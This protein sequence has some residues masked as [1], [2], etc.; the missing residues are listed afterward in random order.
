[1]NSDDYRATHIGRLLLELSHDF[2]AEANERIARKGFAFVRAAHIAVVAQVDEE[3]TE[4]GR[5]VERVGTTKQAVNKIIRQ[6]EELDVIRLE[7]SDRDSRVRVVRFTPAG[8]KFLKAAVDAVRQTEELYESEL[9]AT[10]FAS[11]K[12][13][14]LRLAEKRD[15]FSRT[16]DES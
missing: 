6:L 3:G 8:R 9:G 12:K 16:Y 4:L 14:L 13:N 7:T 15:V 10:A 1:M 2:V 5:V 11:L